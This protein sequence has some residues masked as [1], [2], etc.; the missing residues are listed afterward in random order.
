LEQNGSYRHTWKQNII[1]F[2]NYNTSEVTILFIDLLTG[3]LSM[4]AAHNQ[5]IEFLNTSNFNP[6]G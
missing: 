5:L 3:C 6:C 4:Q 2:V 1:L